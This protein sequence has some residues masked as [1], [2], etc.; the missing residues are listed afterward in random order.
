[1]GIDSPLTFILTCTQTKLTVMKNGLLTILLV[2][3]SIVSHAQNDDYL[4]YAYVSYSGYFGK[5]LGSCSQTHL[6][7]ISPI[8][9][10]RTTKRI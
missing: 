4:E 1:M 5:S 8:L 2:I 7:Y 10:L 9:K 6:L 3:V